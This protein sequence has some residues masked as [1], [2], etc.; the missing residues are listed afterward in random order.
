LK[1][2]YNISGGVVITNVDRFSDAFMRG[3]QEGF[4]ITE[5]NKKTVKTVDD[6]NDAISG[7]GQGDSVLLKVIDKN[8]T[9]RIVAVKLQ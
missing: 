4:V 3:L 6:L 9:E 2:K 1:D 7:K 8:G 5:A